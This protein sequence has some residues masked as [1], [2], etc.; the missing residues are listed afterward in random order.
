MGA[1]GR[2]L[3]A[4]GPRSRPAPD[5]GEPVRALHRLDGVAARGRGRD[6][7][8]PRRSRGRRDGEAGD[9][10][11]RRRRHPRSDRRTRSSTSPRPAGWSPG[12]SRPSSAWPPRRLHWTSP[13]GILKPPFR[14]HRQARRPMSPRPQIDHIRRPQILAAAIEVIGERGMAGTRI[15]DV[16]ERAG[17]SPAGVLYWFNSKDELLA[18]ALTSDEERFAENLVAAAGRDPG[19]GREAGRDHRRLRRGQQLDAVDRALDPRPARRRDPAVPPVARRPLAFHP[20]PRD[21][22]RDRAGRLQPGEPGRGGAR[23]SRA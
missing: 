6:R 21:S 17:T 1:L 5:R 23:R 9:R 22:Q 11:A 13:T 15:A 14:F 3:A 7:R 20:R 10:A 8:V 2:A 18:E 16:A 19:L 12:G 4:G